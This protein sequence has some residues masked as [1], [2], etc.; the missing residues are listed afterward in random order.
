VVLCAALAG[1]S[2][3]QMARQPYYRPLVP[4]AFFADGRAARP[5][6]PGTVARG[7]LDDNVSFYTGKSGKTDERAQAA[8]VLAVV[9]QNPLGAV[10]MA[11][12]SDPYEDQFPYEIT[13]ALLKRGQERYQIYCAV[14]H[15]RAG[16]GDGMIVRRGFTKPPSFHE[17]RLRQ[18]RVGYLFHVATRGFGSMPDYASQIPPE[19]RWYIVA[20]IRALQFSRHAPQ[21]VLDAALAGGGKAP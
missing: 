8:G 5:L 10:G 1:C 7:H 12:A 20:Y 9:A 3:Q 16:T 21:T 2:E 15:D 4:S 17:P 18:A 14:C 6:P 19:D 13:E 11:L